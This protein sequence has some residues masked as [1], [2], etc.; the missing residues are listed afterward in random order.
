MKAI[1]SP[2]PRVILGIVFFGIALLDGAMRHC[3]E[4][5]Q[6][7]A[8]LS[9][10]GKWSVILLAAVLASFIVTNM[11]WPLVKWVVNSVKA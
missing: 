4:D 1:T 6:F 3:D 2:I 9:W 7:Y 8:C 5:V 11:V 10:I